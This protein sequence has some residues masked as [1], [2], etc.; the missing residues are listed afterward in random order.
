MNKYCVSVNA[1]EGYCESETL[2]KGLLDA[3]NAV[4]SV[5]GSVDKAPVEV[6]D[7]LLDLQ[8]EVADAIA[9]EKSML[10]V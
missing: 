1:L 3:R 2:S 8:V 10:N 5:Y 9:H 4:E 7:S 6:R